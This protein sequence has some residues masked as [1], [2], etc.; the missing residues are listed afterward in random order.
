MQRCI[1][2]PHQSDKIWLAGVILGWSSFNPSRREV[3]R[4]LL[5][6]PLSSVVFLC[7]NNTM[8]GHMAILFLYFAPTFVH[9]V[10]SVQWVEPLKSHTSMPRAPSCFSLMAIAS[11][12]F[13]NR[14]DLRTSETWTNK[15]I[16]SYPC[17]MTPEKLLPCFEFS[18]FQFV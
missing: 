2:F 4:Q 8:R 17:F 14:V 13:S 5:D 12:F 11:F 1:F 16:E 3:N 9:I 6:F 7:M 15:Q 10:Y 18:E